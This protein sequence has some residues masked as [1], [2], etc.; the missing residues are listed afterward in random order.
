M[1]AVVG[2]PPTPCLANTSYS[3]PSPEYRKF[4]TTRRQSTVPTSLGTRLH[5]VG[6]R[7]A[8]API[9]CP[10]P[11][12]RT[13]IE[14]GHLHWYVCCVFFFLAA[15]FNDRGCASF[16]SSLYTRVKPLT[17]I[18]SIASAG[19]LS[20]PLLY[21]IPLAH[22]HTHPKLNSNIRTNCYSAYRA[23]FV[24]VQLSL[25]STLFVVIYPLCWCIHQLHQ[26]RGICIAQQTVATCP[27][28]SLP[29]FAHFRTRPRASYYFCSITTLV[30]ASRLDQTPP[31]FIS[32]SFAIGLSGTSALLVALSL[33]AAVRP[34]LFYFIYLLISFVVK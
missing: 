21:L 12:N 31:V 4:Y 16:Q 15:G 24:V 1:S 17:S 33:V 13:A 6:A 23:L 18:A 14:S 10:R 34:S 26:P 29:M 7:P 20:H 2:R 22:P 3:C 28:T 25:A 8:R 11:L 5:A 27:S 9:C 32:R 19:H 30:A